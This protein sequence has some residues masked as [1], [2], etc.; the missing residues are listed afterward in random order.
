MTPYPDGWYA[1]AYS[2]ELSRGAAT[3]ATYFGRDW[4]LY[5]SE[6]GQPKVLAAYCPHL[7]AHL[8]HGGC[9]EGETIACPFH[10][11]RFDG[12]GECVAIPYAKK[13]PPRARVDAL[14]ARDLNGFVMVWWSAAN[15]Q[16]TW[17]PPALAE[18]AD[19][20]WTEL[21]RRQWRVRTHVQETNENNCDSAHLAHLHGLVDPQTTAE[22]D[23]AVLHVKTHAKVDAARIGLP[24]ELEGDIEGT[25]W[26]LGMLR[27]RFRIFVDG[28]LLS[29]VTPVDD[30][31]VDIRFAFTLKKLATAELTAQV[32]SMMIGDI[33]RDVEDDIRIW[34]HKQYLERPMLCDGD[35]PI[36]VA[37]KWARA[38][39]PQ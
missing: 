13:I 18:L 5:R 6:S 11:W 7:G 27:Q 10:K 28:I 16:P 32:K 24:G 1:V 12:A 35:G 30:E 21:E 36:Q 38:F 25:H 31:H 22:L 17:E 20:E 23:G 29:L 34:E 15:A 3:P 26:G 9:V 37:R 14:A 2:E 39:Y 19:A 33:A 4:V 8:G